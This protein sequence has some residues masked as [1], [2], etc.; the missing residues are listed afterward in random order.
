MF[1][2][3]HAIKIVHNSNNTSDLYYIYWNLNSTSLLHLYFALPS[4]TGKY[5]WHFVVRDKNT[6]IYSTQKKEFFGLILATFYNKNSTSR[7]Q[8][9]KKNWVFHVGRGSLVGDP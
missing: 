3:K 1:L 8:K 7:P 2:I 9:K 6:F 4:R 5:V